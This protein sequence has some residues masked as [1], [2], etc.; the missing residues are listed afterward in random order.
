[1]A[2]MSSSPPPMS[3]LEDEEITDDDILDESGF[4]V[5]GVKLRLEVGETNGNTNCLFL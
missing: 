3:P 5:T 1:M 4:D 2:W